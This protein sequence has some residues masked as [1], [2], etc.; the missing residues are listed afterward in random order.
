L[1]TLN[2]ICHVRRNID[3]E[4]L[5]RIITL[6]I[7]L[8]REGREGRKI[9]T[10][11]I[12]GDEK[13]VLD[14]SRQLILNPLQGHDEKERA[15]T[16]PNL[17]ETL[18]EL[19]LLDGAFV[20]AGKGTVLA[21][22]RHVFSDARDLDIPLG[23]GSRHIAAASV[24]KVT[25]AVAVVVSESSVVRVVADGKIVTEIIPELWLIQKSAFSNKS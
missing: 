22:G 2:K 10:M 13:K 8:S 1:E 3:K 6:S 23:L 21:A 4:V 18:K 20:V 5:K 7:E 12:V 24:T 19:A 25:R 16:H 15:I 17:R 14:L 9:G 11:F